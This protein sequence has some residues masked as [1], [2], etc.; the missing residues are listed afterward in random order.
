MSVS[1]SFVGD[2]NKIRL[3]NEDVSES[4]RTPEVSRGASEVAKHPAV[5]AGL[6]EVQRNL[7]GKGGAVL[8]GRDIGTVVFP[9]AAVKIFLDA[10]AEVRAQRRFEELNLNGLNASYEQI[11]EEIRDRDRRDTERN[12]A[13]LRAAEDAIIVD[14]SK[15]TPEMVVERIILA[16]RAAL[17]NP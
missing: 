2:T 9:D 10:S 16:V 1:F 14:S 5:R 13:P 15:L 4:I 17:G 3:N 8:E 7:A 6:L 11:I 12:I